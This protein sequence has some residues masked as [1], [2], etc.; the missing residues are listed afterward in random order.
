MGELLAHRIKKTAYSQTLKQHEEN[1]AALCQKFL[2]TCELDKIG[3]LSGILHDLG[4]AKSLFQAYLMIDEDTNEKINHAFAGAIYLYDHFY[5]LDNTN[6]VIQKCFIESV[7]LIILSHHSKL[8]DMY[9]PDKEMPFHS[10]LMTKKEILDYEESV[11]TFFSIFDKRYLQ[12]LIQEA[13]QQ[14]QTLFLRMKEHVNKLKPFLEEQGCK[15][16]NGTLL[17]FQLGLQTRLLQSALRDADCYD[18]YLFMNHPTLSYN[19]LQPPYFEKNRLHIWETLEEKLNA[20][21]LTLQQGNK[22]TEINQLR[23]Q[24]SLECYQAGEKKQGIYTLAAPTGSGKTLASLRFALAHA[25]KHKHIRHIYYVI[26]YLSILTQNAANLRDVLGEKDEVI[27][28]EHYSSLVIDDDEQHQLFTERWDHAVI[29]TSYVQVLNALFHGSKQNIRRMHQLTDAIL[30][31]DEIQSLPVSCKNMFQTA[32]DYLTEFCGSTVLLCSATQPFPPNKLNAIPP[33]EEILSHLKIYNEAFQ[34]VRYED[35]TQCIM[36]TDELVKVISEDMQLRQSALI[37]LNQKKRAYD[38]YHELKTL[39][40][41]D[42]KIFFLANTMCAQHKEDMIKEMTTALK[43]DTKVICVSTSLIEAGVDLSFETV[44]RA[45]TGLDSI[46]QAAGRCNRNR[47]YEEGITYIFS[48]ADENLSRLSEIAR[49]KALTLRVLKKFR[50]NPLQYDNNIAS[51]KTLHSYYKFYYENLSAYKSELAIETDYIKKVGQV[52]YNLYDLL[53]ENEQSIKQFS[54]DEKKQCVMRQA[55]RKAG[56]LFEVIPN[57][58]TTVIVPYGKGEDI[59]T[60]LCADIKDYERI[61][62]LIK[63]AQRYSIEVYTQGNH[64]QDCFTA[65]KDLGVMILNDGYYDETCGFHMMAQKGG[66]FL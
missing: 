10:K 41:K 58:T 27:I 44:W 26:P 30:I 9:N 60:E 20:H 24:I 39:L 49:A 54:N 7:S 37:I 47:E 8:Y 6:E 52:T 50:D 4:K 66:Y 45:C 19:V 53:S 35:K 46:I 23:N 61:D 3:Y 11:N 48:D 42:Y 38:V 63:Q 57:A 21:L 18:T 2:T 43:K 28:L 51:Q 40:D 65:I 15:K 17:Y 31:F 33:Y 25:K 16:K 59:I 64:Y 34:R 22:Q 13:I 14:Y 62:T 5:N 32:I 29:L 12:T 36:H 56:D 1:T 55:F